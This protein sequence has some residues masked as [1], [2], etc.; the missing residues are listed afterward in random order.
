M[1]TP[2]L[3]EQHPLLVNLEPAQ[4][5]H[6]AR[7]GEVESYN[8]GE[9]IVVEG[10][11]GDALFLILSGQVAVLVTASSGVLSE[12][13]VT[14]APL[15]VQ[16]EAGVTLPTVSRDDVVQETHRRTLYDVMDLAAGFFEAS[17]LGRF[18]ARA[19]DY[20]AGRDLG[21]PAPRVPT[22]KGARR[23]FDGQRGAGHPG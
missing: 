11:L 5:D 23:R 19:R 18:G 21:R 3:L 15:V 8:P 6:L 20:L 9:A 16:G 2:T 17:L 10:S 1:S 4:L 22:G 12:C 13:E 14:G 7:A